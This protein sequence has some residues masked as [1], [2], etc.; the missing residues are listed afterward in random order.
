MD[1]GGVKRV[2][3]NDQGSPPEGINWVEDKYYELC[4]YAQFSSKQKIRLYELR[5]SRNVTVGG[6]QQIFSVETRLMQLE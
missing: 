1:V 2:C 5:N 6:S 4:Y 3:F